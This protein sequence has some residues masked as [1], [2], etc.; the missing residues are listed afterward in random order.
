MLVLGFK[1]SDQAVIFN[2]YSQ[3]SMIITP[4]EINNSKVI[5]I[6]FIDDYQNFEIIRGGILPPGNTKW[7]HLN[8]YNW[9]ADAE[10]TQG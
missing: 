1:I 8:P 7:P 5:R 9:S 6:G 4:C 10:G 3:Q 2:K